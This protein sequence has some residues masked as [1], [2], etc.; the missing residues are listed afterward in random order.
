MPKKELI[1][2]DTLSLPDELV[3]WIGNAPVY[4]SSG[5]SGARTVYIDSDGG[6]Y[7]KIAASG[8]LLRSSQL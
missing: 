8:S 4:E 5:E 3:R 6:A 2:I 7:L 1:D